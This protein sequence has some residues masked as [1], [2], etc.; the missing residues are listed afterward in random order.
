LFNT[1][2]LVLSLKDKILFKEWEKEVKMQQKSGSK[3]AEYFV[4]EECWSFKKGELRGLKKGELR[5]FKRGQLQGRK[6][7]SLEFIRKLISEGY[8][9]EQAL[10][11][12]G[13]SSLEYQQILLQKHLLDKDQA[14]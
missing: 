1:S 11:M 14:S 9:E 6:L 2:S 12:T 3:V 5:G 13:T 4:N 7:Q 10:M 8:S